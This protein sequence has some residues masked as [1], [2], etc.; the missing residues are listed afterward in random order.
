M[1]KRFWFRAKRY[2]F[3]WE[4][5]TWEGWVIMMLWTALV[6]GGFVVVDAHSH[7]ISDTLLIVVPNTLIVT[8]M[9]LVVCYLTGEKPRWR[10]GGKP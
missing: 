4:P 6:V 2:G 7:S 9:L 1:T 5:A 8:A 10:W 3:G